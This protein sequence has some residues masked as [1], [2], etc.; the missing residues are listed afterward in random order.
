MTIL[1]YHQEIVKA[2]TSPL[3]VLYEIDLTDIG[4]DIFRFADNSNA[5]ATITFKTHIWTP[6]PITITGIGSTQGE[7]PAK[8]VLVVSNVNKVLQAAVASLGD[9]IGGKVTR[10]RTFRK[11]LADGTS[12]ND[13]AHAPPD[14]YI[15]DQKTS[16]NKTNI[17]WNLISK[18]DIEDDKLPGR[19]MLRDDVG[20]QYGFP[21]LAVSSRMRY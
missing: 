5:G 12:P 20:S 4:G 3:V 2:A 8:P 7:A 6:F 17:T 1:D 15:I 21:G 10:Y 13:N 9:V 11:F 16:H 18:M 14:V 19:Q